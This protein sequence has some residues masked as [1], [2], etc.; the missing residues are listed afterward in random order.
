MRSGRR[1][2]KVPRVDFL[3]R[4]RGPASEDDYSEES[5]PDFYEPPVDFYDPRQ[6]FLPSIFGE[7]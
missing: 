4:L 7:E 3:I 1:R 2:K 5:F 6:D